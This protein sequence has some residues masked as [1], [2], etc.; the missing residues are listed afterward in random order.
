M[1]HTV[2]VPEL[3]R[4]LVPCAIASIGTTDQSQVRESAAAIAQE[5]QIAPHLE[6]FP[7]SARER[8]RRRHA[9]ASLSRN[10]TIDIIHS[11]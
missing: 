5:I 3:M 2:V 11:C 6:M 1:A 8:L 10:Q 4:L 9:L 7:S